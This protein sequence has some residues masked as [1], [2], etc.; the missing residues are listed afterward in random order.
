MAAEVVT[1]EQYFGDVVND[2]TTRRAQIVEVA[3][4][5]GDTRVIYLRVPLANMFGYATALRSVTQ[6]RAT[7]T[8]EPDSYQPVPEDQQREL[9]A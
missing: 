9:L 2:L 6:G 1:P 5:A 8:M 3:A 7:Y 4:S